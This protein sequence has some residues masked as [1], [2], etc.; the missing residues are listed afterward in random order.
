M[1]INSMVALVPFAPARVDES[2]LKV[3]P[4]V[5]RRTQRITVFGG[6]GLRMLQVQLRGRI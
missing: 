2:T 1:G 3:Q 6:W 4:P 5:S